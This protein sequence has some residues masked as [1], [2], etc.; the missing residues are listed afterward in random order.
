[1]RDA[2]VA[3]LGLLDLRRTFFRFGR[4]RNVGARQASCASATV[5]GFFI[6]YIVTRSTD[7]LQVKPATHPPANLLLFLNAHFLSPP[8]QGCSV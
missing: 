2:L 3:S 1:M 6:T 8:M 7:Q 5:K 4:M